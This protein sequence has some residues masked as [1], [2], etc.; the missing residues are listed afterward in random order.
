MARQT[1]TETEYELMKILWQAD[2]PMSLG[3]ILKELDGKW[4]RNTVGT[5]LVRLCEKGVVSY[6]QKGK[7]YLYYPILKESDYTMQETR[8]LLHKLYNGKVGNLVAS[9][10]E[11]KE[12]SQEEIEDLRKLIDT[13]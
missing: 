13:E 7:S 4:V 12:I 6:H 9:L 1:V 2:A 3:E 8:S 11:N 10:F 5:M